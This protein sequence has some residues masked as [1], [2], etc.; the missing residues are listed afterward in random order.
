MTPDID[1][2]VVNHEETL[3]AS[4]VRVE[5]DAMTSDNVLVLSFVT[6]ALVNCPDE[7]LSVFK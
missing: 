3:C 7:R 2:L 5:V 4:P 1:T 6:S